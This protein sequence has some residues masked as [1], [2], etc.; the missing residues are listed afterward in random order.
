[1][2]TYLLLLSYAPFRES[3]WY[4]LNV[5]TQRMV[6]GSL[7]I[8][9]VLLSERLDV[10]LL[11]AVM[12]A[13]FWQQCGWLAHDFL[14]HQVSYFRLINYVCGRKSMLYQ[15]PVRNISTNN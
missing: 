8:A 11:G 4:Y 7:S 10:N 2:I 5:A 9:C 14:H 6:L 12:L 13:I 15:I 3:L 1:M